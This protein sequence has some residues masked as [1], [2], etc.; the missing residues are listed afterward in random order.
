MDLGEKFHVLLNYYCQNVT[1][2]TG[3]IEGWTGFWCFLFAVRGKINGND[4]D[5]ASCEWLVGWMTF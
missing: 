5:D 3:D 2:L 4:N 1:D